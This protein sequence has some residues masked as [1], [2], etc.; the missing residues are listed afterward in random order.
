MRLR[1]GL[2]DGQTA[3]LS[4][5]AEWSDFRT[6]LG[7]TN[8][9]QSA[10]QVVLRLYDDRHTLVHSS[11]PMTLTPGEWRQLYRP[12]RELAGRS[13]VRNGRAEVEVKGGAG[14]LVHASLV[15]NRTNDAA[16]LWATP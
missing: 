7:L 12:F 15:D 5:L 10:A 9:S 11:G 8:A 4:G 13:N 3:V 2:V 6:N 1:D 14:V 16:T